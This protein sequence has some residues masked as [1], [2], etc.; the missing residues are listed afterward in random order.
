MP[1]TGELAQVQGVGV[2]NKKN[3]QIKMV[4][5]EQG[6]LFCAVVGGQAQR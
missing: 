3:P 2:K 1:S 6:I 4:K 5:L